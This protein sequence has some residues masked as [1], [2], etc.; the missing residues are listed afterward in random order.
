MW[1]TTAQ[2]KQFMSS[3][4]AVAGFLVTFLAVCQYVDRH[5]PK[6]A[7]LYVCAALPCV[8]M[9]GVIASLAIYL[10]EERDGYMRD[11]AMRSLL[12]GTAA[13]MTVNLF[14]MFLHAFGWGGQ[15][16]VGVEMWA[17]AGASAVASIAYAVANRLK[18]GPKEDN[19]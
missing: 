6:G 13:S 11:L 16:P 17:F 2:K 12:W 9:C 18:C 1:L 4:A 3:M 14:L 10:H 5:H 7:A 15:V 8:A 19:R